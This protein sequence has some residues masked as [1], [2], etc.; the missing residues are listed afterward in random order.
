MS[1]IEKFNKQKESFSSSKGERFKFSEGANRIRIL[2]EP[3]MIQEDYNYGIC[4]KDCGFKG[5]TKYLSWV[6]DLKDNKVK[7]MR[8][9]YSI[10]NDVVSLMSSKD[11]GYGFESFP[12]PYNITVNAVGAG[13]KEV[14][15]SVIPDRENTEVD[16]AIIDEVSK[17]TAPAGLAELFK[18][19]NEEEHRKDGT[20]DK[21]HGKAKEEELD[22]IEYPEDDINPEDIP[23]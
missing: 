15:Y 4:Y 10:M 6:L 16:P 21:L 17:K 20:W 12:M 8:I 1:F 13:T 2:A 5:S 9:P 18:K 7:M 14:K 3:E 22:T 23:F 19:W 11:Q